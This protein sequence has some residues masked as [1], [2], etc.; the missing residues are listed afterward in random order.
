MASLPPIGRLFQSAQEPI[1]LIQLEQ[2]LRD[3]DPADQ[4]LLKKVSNLI[5][6][7]DQPPGRSDAAFL[8][9]AETF[10][11]EVRNPVLRRLISERL[12]LRTIVAALRRRHRGEQD[13]PADQPWG[14]GP[15]VRTME[16]QWQQRAFGMEPLVPWISEAVTLLESDDLVGFERLQFEIVWKI[17]DQVGFGHYFDFEALVIYLNRWSLVARWSCYKEEAA[18]ERFRH[19]ITNG[20]GS[21]ADCLPVASST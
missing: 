17:L 12:N 18:K 3:L 14:F 1:S 11:R 19:L 9:E 5:A 16:R 20:L 8:Q 2:R 10:F 15:W 21:F 4:I 13:G 7:S 6:W